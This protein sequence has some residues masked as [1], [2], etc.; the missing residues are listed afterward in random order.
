MAQEA[1]AEAYLRL[2]SGNIEDLIEANEF[3]CNRLELILNYIADC[4]KR[5][6]IENVVSSVKQNLHIF[7]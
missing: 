5:E 7:I 1:D 3:M 2:K 6:N 4:L